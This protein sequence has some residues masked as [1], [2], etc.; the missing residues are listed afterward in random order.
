MVCVLYDG[1]FGVNGDLVWMGDFGGA[2]GV[3]WYFG[4]EGGVWLC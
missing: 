4:F 3:D 1:A 2:F